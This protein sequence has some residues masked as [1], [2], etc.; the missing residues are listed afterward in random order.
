VTEE[1]CTHDCLPT[2][3][4]VLDKRSAQIFPNT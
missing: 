3:R 1:S 4:N 2:F